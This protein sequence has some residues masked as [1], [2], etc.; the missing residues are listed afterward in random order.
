MFRP[1]KILAYFFISILAGCATPTSVVNSG[2][3][4]R[5]ESRMSPYDLAR[6]IDRNVDDYAIAGSLY[7]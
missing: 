2:V 3:R 5:F 4:A 1:N 6:C 7:I